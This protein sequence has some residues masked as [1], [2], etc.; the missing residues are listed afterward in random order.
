MYLAVIF[1][2]FGSRRGVEVL[3]VVFIGAGMGGVGM[4][5]VF[6]AVGEFD[7][8]F[9]V[10]LGVSDLWVSIREVEI[11]RFPARGFL[12]NMNQDEC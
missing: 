5:V 7:T 2:P 10:S 9:P 1:E 12:I 11:L 8:V 6:E 4:G 3:M